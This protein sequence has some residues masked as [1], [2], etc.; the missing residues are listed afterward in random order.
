MK[1][2]T[3]TLP[4]SKQKKYTIHIGNGVLGRITH[5]YNLKNY[6]HIFII[7]DENVGPLFLGKIT[8][9]LPKNTSSIVLPSGEKAKHI[10]SVTMIWEAMYNARCDRKSFVINLGGGVIGDM[11]GFAAS[12]YMRGVDFLNI[13]TTLLACVDASVGGKT[14]IDFAGIKNLIGTFNQPIGVIIDVKT[15]TTLPERQLVS[16][17]AEVIKHGLI[18]DKEYFENVTAKDPAEFTPEEM[19]NIIFTSCKIKADIVQKDET[20]RDLRKVLNFGHT[21]GHAIESLSFNT[22]KPLLHGEAIYF[23]MMIEANISFI[24]GIL[25]LSD[26][27]KIKNCLNRKFDV[28]IK[29]D[30]MLEK[31]KS[32]KKNEGGNINFTLLKSI[33]NAVVSQQI[34]K[35][36]IMKALQEHQL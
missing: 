30:A 31:M 19:E 8:S 7:T 5:L 9:V 33:G 26:F 3:L 34:S 16:G 22:D 35:T 10:A 32:D 1:Q 28:S 12:T 11:G 21:V 23:G 24:S 4:R 18:R 20:E 27:Q 17:F 36:V 13:P 15:L 2:I 6:S 14:G 29:I 25:P